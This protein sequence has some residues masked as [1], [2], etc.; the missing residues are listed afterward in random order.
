MFLKF[1]TF[2]FSILDANL[3]ETSDTYNNV[4]NK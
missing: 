1:S 2:L 3:G 4:Y